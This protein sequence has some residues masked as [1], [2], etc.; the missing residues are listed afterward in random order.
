M[1]ETRVSGANGDGRS[2]DLSGERPEEDESQEGI[3]LLHRP[4]QSE[5]RHGLPAGQALKTAYPQDRS[6]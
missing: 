1:N 3:G 2:A 4:K 5:Q 6:D